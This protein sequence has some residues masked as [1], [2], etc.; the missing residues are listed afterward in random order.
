M[1]PKIKHPNFEFVI[2][3]TKKKES[4]R[5]FLVREEKILLM[6]KAS[7][8]LSEALRAIK[9]IVNNCCM[10]TTFDVDRLTIF[11]LEYLFLQ[12]RAISVNNI[13]S[14]SYRDN[15]DQQVY[16]FKID[17]TQIQVNF[18]EKI[19]NKIKV[20]DNIGI[21][22]KYPAASLLNEAEIF[23]KDQDG[24]F[25][26]VLKCIDKIYDQTDVYDPSNYTIAELEQFLDEC[27]VETLEK[28]QKFML[29]VPRLHHEIHYKNSLGN[30][31]TIVLST[32]SD[33]FTFR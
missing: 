32:L 20:D 13:V 11:D 14:V 15:E 17:I 19:E 28:I 2:P 10:N 18:P 16:D 29:N 5:P 22:M 6:A 27:G 24:F 12:I 4:F 3:S 21:L 31:R 33:F 26:L 23:A 25:E 9:Q 7:E 8:D 1:L 30:D